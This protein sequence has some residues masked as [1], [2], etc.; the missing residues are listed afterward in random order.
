MQCTV[1]AGVPPQVKRGNGRNRSGGG[2]G[3]AAHVSTSKAQARSP[4]RCLIGTRRI[5][6]HAERGLAWIHTAFEHPPLPRQAGAGEVCMWTGQHPS[7][8]AL[9]AWVALRRAVSVT[10]SDGHGGQRQT[11]ITGPTG[12]RA[13]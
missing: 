7:D 4:D 9:V 8:R 5:C 3:G 12:N 10:T 6:S 11:A 1:T 2:G 13:I